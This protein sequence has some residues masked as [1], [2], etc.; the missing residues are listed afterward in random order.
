MEY[1]ATGGFVFLTV[2]MAV[3]IWGKLAP[4]VVFTV[5]PLAAAALM[6]FSVEEISGFAV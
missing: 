3:L 6:G 1:M 5:L 2:M 4:P